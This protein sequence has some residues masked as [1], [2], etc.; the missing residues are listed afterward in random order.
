LKHVVKIYLGNMAAYYIQ[1]YLV[2][3]QCTVRSEWILHHT[4]HCTHT[5]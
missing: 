2:C 3:E 5:K 4:V 1:S